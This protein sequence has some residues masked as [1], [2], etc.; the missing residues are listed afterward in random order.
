MTLEQ[1]KSRIRSQS[2]TIQLSE[3][4]GLPFWIW[5]VE[6]HRKADRETRG[7]CC[8]NHIIGLPK[9]NGKEMPL[10][11]YQERVFSAL[12]EINDSIK[13][14]HL[15]IKKCRG[16]GI[17]ELML[18]FMAWL[19]LRDDSLRG[20]QM[21]IITGPRLELAIDLIDRMKKLFEG[22]AK[23][24]TDKTVII[25]NGCTIR[26]YPSNAN[27]SRGQPNMQFI[28]L[29]EADF[30]SPAEQRIAREAAE[31]YIGKNNPFIVMV[32]T[33]NLPTGL[34]DQIEREPEAKCLYRRIF[35]P[36]TDCVGRIYSEEEIE[37]AKASPSFEREYNLKYGHGEGNIWPAE[38]LEKVTQDYDLALKGGSKILAVDPA[39]GSSKFAIAG[40]EKID[41]IIYVKDALEITDASPSAM[42]DLVAQ[43]AKEYG[44]TMVLIDGSNPGLIRDLKDQNI[45]AHA[46]NFQKELSEMTI[47]AARVVKEQKVC[48]HPAFKDLLAQ[49]RSAEFNEKGHPDKKKLGFDLGD[50]FLM[51]LNHFRTRDISVIDLDYEA[52]IH[53]YTRGL[54]D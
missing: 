33:P 22:L 52:S 29:D 1:L 47:N 42:L 48:I 13:D 27:S 37:R 3:L 4:K 36:Y 23:F 20:A 9:K 31:G 15:W 49:L 11:D 38:L 35:I 44:N 30:F 50:T 21:A 19:A 12:M 16:S 14:K 2:N 7:R 5:N 10:F 24:D 32:S 54:D 25:L 28:L 26:A 6:E 53:G 45:H 46:V 34:Y 43:K 51:G 39:Y 17:T 41:G 8:F 18:R 40:F